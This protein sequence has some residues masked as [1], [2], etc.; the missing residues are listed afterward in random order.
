MMGSATTTSESGSELAPTA[1]GARATLAASTR[2][3]CAWSVMVATGQDNF[4]V[5]AV[6]LGFGDVLSGLVASIPLLLGAVLQL[7]TPYAVRRLGSHKKWIL[8][9]ASL[10][11]LSFVPLVIAAALGSMH[12]AVLFAVTAIYWFAGIGGGAAWH[13]FMSQAVPTSVRT[14]FFATRSRWMNFALVLATLANGWILEF[15]RTH[16]QVLLT[17]AVLLGIAAV[18]RGLSAAYLAMQTEREAMPP[19]YRILTLREF[20]GRIRQRGGGRVMLYI[21]A[22]QFGLTISTPFIQPFLLE[23][24]K[25]KDNF[26]WY[27]VLMAA[28]LV[29]KIAALPLWAKW[30]Q[31]LGRGDQHLGISRILLI[32]GLLIIPI[33]GLWLI[34]ANL[35]FA[36][37]VQLFTGFALAGYELA[38]FLRLFQSVQN[39]E[40]TSVITWYFLVSHVVLLLGSLLGAKLLEYGLE[41]KWGYALVFGAAMLARFMTIPIL[42]GVVRDSRM[43]SQTTSA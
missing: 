14:K 23:Q 13:T 26:T 31:T 29:G 19:D 1:R 39:H 17:L 15:G 37:A 12:P 32:S 22:V 36:V 6:A 21:L 40:R 9:L 43:P 18:A 3:G 41:T 5:L 35:W 42:I 30:V 16:G 28:L 10:Q 2:D 25:L 34:G 7:S 33:P 11:A 20:L 8:V 38:S 4:V 27:G 24:L